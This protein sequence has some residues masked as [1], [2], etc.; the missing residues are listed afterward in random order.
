MPTNIKVAVETYQ[1]YGLAYLQNLNCFLSTANKKYENFQNIIANR[2]ES[3]SFKLPSRHTASNGLVATFDSIEDRKQTLSVTQAANTSYTMTNEERIFYY[4]KTGDKTLDDNETTSIAELGAKVEIDIAKNATSSVVDMFENSPTF[5]QKQHLSGPYKFFYTGITDGFV[6]P[7]SS[8][9]QLSTMI[10]RFSTTGSVK[11]GIKSYIPDVIKDAIVGNGLSQ[12]VPDRNNEIAMSW[13]IGKYGSPGVTYYQSN[14][15]PTHIAGTVGNEPVNHTLTVLSTN[16]PSG[17]NITQITFDGASADDANAIKEGDLLEFVDVSGYENLRTLT[18]IGH[19]PTTEPVQF[20]V[21]AD[22]ASVGTEVVV[23]LI[24]AS[25]GKGLSAVSG[26]NQNINA[27]IIAGMKA[28]VMPSHRAGLICSG[29]ALYLAMPRLPDQ[30]P[31]TTANAIDPETG[32]AIRTTYGSKFGENVKGIVHDT[33][34]GSTLI[35]EY[36]SRILLPL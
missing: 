8:F 12:F 22:A 31:F 14:L 2:G 18:F 20:R 24:A 19:Y 33:I 17:Q 16:D 10:T 23:K 28:R 15:L 27:N 3:V 13:E 34:W 21:I 36:C 11:R 29:N 6:D 1:Q 5:G 25:E 4:E 7:L 35:P 30:S 26:K 32:A 9:Q